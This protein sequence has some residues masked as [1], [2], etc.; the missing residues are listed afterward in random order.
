MSAVA[1][2]SALSVHRGLLR[3]ISLAPA[4]VALVLMVAGA[5]G[6]QTPAEPSPDRLRERA[7]Q[8]LQDGDLPTAAQMLEQLGD[9][10]VPQGYTM[11]GQI[12][13]DLG[14]HPDA[15]R[16]F[17]RAAAGGDVMAMVEGGRLLSDPAYGLNDPRR[18][19]KLWLAAAERGSGPGQYEVGRALM[20]G[21]GARQDDAAGADWLEQSARQCFAPAQLAYALALRE[22]RGREADGEEAFAWIVAAERASETWERPDLDRLARLEVEITGYM[23]SAQVRSAYCRGLDILAASCGTGDILFRIERWLVCE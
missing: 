8:A 12:K 3:A 13:R 2:I 5:A 11:L 18:A 15:A 9:R 22:G 10:G 17:E 21:R 1:A 14:D 20:T 6:Q 19:F 16:W 23:P 7:L 4:L